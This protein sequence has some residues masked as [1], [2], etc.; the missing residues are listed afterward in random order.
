MHGNSI[1]GSISKDVYQLKQ[2]NFSGNMKWGKK[3]ILPYINIGVNIGLATKQRGRKN[4][5]N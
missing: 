4:P 5:Q 2:H 1:Q 3:K